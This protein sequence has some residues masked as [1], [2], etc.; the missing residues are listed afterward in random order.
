M[1][2]S[3]LR[4]LR[5][6]DLSDNI[7]LATTKFGEIKFVDNMLFVPV[8]NRDTYVYSF[9]KRA[10]SQRRTNVIF[11]K[12]STP[13]IDVDA[14]DLKI[15]NNQFFDLLADQRPELQTEYYRLAREKYCYP[16][17]NRGKLWYDRL[18]PSQVSELN[19][20]YEAWLDVTETHQLPAD[21]AWFNDKLNKLEEE[22][23][24]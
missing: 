8:G 6:N 20:W 16:I 19:E 13:Q 10:W 21:L 23:I 17:V 11:D 1:I 4:S 2:L 12:I 24:V 9:M 15:V 14:L 3:F 7:L 18:L 5:R 22:E